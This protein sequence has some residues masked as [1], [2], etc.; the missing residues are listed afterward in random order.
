MYQSIRMSYQF[1]VDGNRR[2]SVRSA[3]SKVLDKHS[4]HKQNA[5]CEGSVSR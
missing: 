2:N 5:M 3:S 1:S 4:A